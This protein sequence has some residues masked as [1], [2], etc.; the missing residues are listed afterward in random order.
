VKFQEFDGPHAVPAEI[1]RGAIEWF[2]EVSSG[3]RGTR[4]ERGFR[5][6]TGYRLKFISSLKA[7]REL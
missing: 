4:A 6:T 1:A 7:S 3:S 2:L 5:P